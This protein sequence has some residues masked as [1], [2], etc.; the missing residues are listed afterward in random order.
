MNFFGD[1]DCAFNVIVDA[2]AGFALQKIQE[3][4]LGYLRNIELFHVFI[5]QGWNKRFAV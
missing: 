3:L 4:L 2:H 1:F 5:A